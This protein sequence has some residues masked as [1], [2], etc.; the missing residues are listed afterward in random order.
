[1]GGAWPA[2]SLPPPA[3]R[4]PGESSARGPSPQPP[5]P[6]QGHPLPEHRQRHPALLRLRRRSLLAVVARH[7]LPLCQTPAWRGEHGQPHTGAVPVAGGALATGAPPA[8]AARRTAT[9]RT[10]R[11]SATATARS[12]RRHRSRR[13]ADAG[14][15][16]EGQ[17]SRGST[18]RSRTQPRPTRRRS[19]TSTPWTST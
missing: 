18:P 4:A 9:S 10:K 16:R 2:G 6:A 13:H 7:R 19:R 8:A 14:G 15:R 17:D 11:G 1:M 3:G 5:P 12:R